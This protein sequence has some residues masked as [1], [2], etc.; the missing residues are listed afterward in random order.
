MCAISFIWQ[1]SIQ[2]KYLSSNAD[3][4]LHHA[5][6][7]MQYMTMLPDQTSCHIAGLGQSHPAANEQSRALVVVI[8]K[9]LAGC[10][11]CHS[12]IAAVC[13]ACVQVA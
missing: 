10:C 4:T 6:L 12:P 13:M 11:T 5:E 8:C 2:H 1:G 7:S 3:Q 9:R